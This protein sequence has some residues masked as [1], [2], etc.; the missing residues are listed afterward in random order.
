MSKKCWRKIQ[1]SA[2]RVNEN[3]R[4]STICAEYTQGKT[5][6]DKNSHKVF[7]KWV[8]E[9][10]RQWRDCL[11]LALGDPRPQI[12]Q[13]FLCSW[14]TMKTNQEPWKLWNYREKPWKPTRNH[15]KPW[16]CFENHKKTTK[17]H[18][19]PCTMHCEDRRQKNGLRVVTTCA[20][21]HT[22]TNGPGVVILFRSSSSSDYI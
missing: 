9:P 8:E 20:D 7:I 3:K 11:Y 14:K 17:N 12:F 1:C 19:K 6:S 10:S 22:R 5:Q 4:V 16:N 18:G 2:H 15:E 13:H 21:E